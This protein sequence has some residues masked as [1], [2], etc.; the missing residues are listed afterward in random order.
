M[1]KNE[2]EARPFVE[3]EEKDKPLIIDNL[4]SFLSED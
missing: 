1:F 4:D 3:N 2:E